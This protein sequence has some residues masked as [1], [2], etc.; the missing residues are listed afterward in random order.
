MSANEDTDR[1]PIELSDGGAKR[2]FR[3]PASDPAPYKPKHRPLW[4]NFVTEA[5]L[6][7]SAVAI[8]LLLTF[9]LMTLVKPQTNPYVDIVGYLVGP[10]ILVLGLVLIP[11]GILFRSWRIRRRHP[12]QHLAFR[13]PRVDLNDPTQRRAAKFFVIGT[14]VLLPVVGVSSYQGYHYT[15]SSRFCAEACHSV[16][17]PQATTY[18]HSAHARVACA[19]CHIGSGAGWF[20]KS[21]LSGTRQV[22]AMWQD[23]YSRPIPPAIHHLRPARETCERC[24]WPDK[25]FGAQL[26]EIVYFASD[27]A[28]T[29]HEIDMLLKTGGADHST[30]KPQGIHS[31]VAFEG[32][33]EYIA[34]DGALQDIPW[35]KFTDEDGKAIVYRS[36]GRP[37]SDPAPK[38]QLRRMDCMDCHNRPAHRFRA[39][40]DVVDIFLDMGRIDSSLPYVKREAVAALCEPYP[41]TATAMNRI[42]GK[43]AA[44]YEQNHP[45]I[46]RERR[47]AVNRSI[48]GVRD[49]YKQTIFPDMKV[50]WRTYPDNIGHKISPGCFRCHEGKHVDQHGDPIS[51]RCDMCHTFLNPVDGENGRVIV[52][53]GDFIHPVPL[54]G[55]HDRL[56]CNLCHTGGVSPSATCEGC[57]TT[58]AAFRNGT[59]DVFEQ[60]GIEAD[61]MADSVDCESCHD[62][63]EPT[64]VDAIDEMC[65][66]C[67]DDEGERFEGMLASWKTEAERLLSEVE[68]TADQSAL[69]IL[70]QAGPLHNMGATRVIAEKLKDQRS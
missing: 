55:P 52:Q 58:Q 3:G 62:L 68:A 14:F 36:D 24:H 13:F 48:D 29:R 46:Y 39:P 10:G 5:G 45:D 18:E 41:D 26:R 7:I 53:R 47:D 70:R 42:A 50:D 16:M 31:H 28:N 40:N 19:E 12:E 57:H 49:I 44:F 1:H 67:H 21:K 22:L 25:F 59:L 63:D 33:I 56:R 38:G 30:W 43:L 65:M 37:N 51:H 61:A 2:S 60:F 23:S 69:R 20:V 17:A 64:T 27:E 54:K 32:R 34:T 9:C 35:V 11:L 66:A 6:F 8:I 4:N 15:D